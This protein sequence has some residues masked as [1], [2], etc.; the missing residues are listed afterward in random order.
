LAPYS[1]FETR[2]KR[3]IKYQIKDTAPAT[4]INGTGPRLS[5]AT[6]VE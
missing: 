1:G 4:V 3:M 6:E 5:F 2:K